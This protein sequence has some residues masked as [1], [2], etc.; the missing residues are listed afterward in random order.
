MSGWSEYELFIKTG[1]SDAAY[2]K[3][4]QELKFPPKRVSCTGIAVP[5][6]FGIE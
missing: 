6:R 5:F 1:L 3:G 2:R 4:S